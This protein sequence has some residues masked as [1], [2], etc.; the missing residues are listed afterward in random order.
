LHLQH[1]Q[2]Q[3]NTIPHPAKDAVLESRYLVQEAIVELR[4]HLLSLEI[5]RPAGETVVQI[6]NAIVA[7]LRRATPIEFEVFCDPSSQNLPAFMSVHLVNMAREALSNSLRHGEPTKISVT[8][9]PTT[10]LPGRWS[11]EIR[12]NGCGFEIAAVNGGGF[13][14]QTLQARAV[15]LGGILRVDSMPGSGTTVRVDFNVDHLKSESR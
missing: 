8:L 15:E 5:E 13:G 12:D 11:L 2:R 14:M 1:A 7:R 9:K 10:D 4:Q 3:F 6:L